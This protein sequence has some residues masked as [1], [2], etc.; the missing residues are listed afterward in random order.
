MIKARELL[1]RSRCRTDH[2][3][4]ESASLIDFV[5]QFIVCAPLHPRRVLISL[6]GSWSPSTVL[7][8]FV[9]GLELQL[10]CVIIH[11][12]TRAAHLLTHTRT[13]MTKC[14]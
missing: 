3:G 4:R 6:S 14:S 5:E 1:W 9:F 8:V 11:F 10:G 7:T 12:S 2:V 13:A